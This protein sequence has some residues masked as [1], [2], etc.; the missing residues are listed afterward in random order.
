[1]KRPRIAIVSDPLVQRGG[2]ERVVEVMA[3]TFPDAPVF[4]LLY[5]KESG[6]ASLADRVVPSMLNRIPGATKR[7][8]W[9][10][11]LYPAAIESFDLSGYD[12]ILSSHHSVAKNVL[13]GADQ[14]HISY[15]HTPMRALWERSLERRS[16]PKP[17]APVAETVMRTMRV[18]DYAGAAHVDEF[19]AN[20]L[21][22]QRRIAR[23][24]R[25]ESTIL[26]PPIDTTKFRPATTPAGDYYLVASRLIPYKRVDLAVAATAAIGRRLVVVGAGP[27]VRE[28]QEPHVDYRGHVDDA[29]L[30][31]LMQGARAMIFGAN[32]D[33]GMAPVE[34]MACG[35]PVV[36]YGEGGARETV[37]DG[38][39]GVFS[40]EQSTAAFVDAIRRFETMALDPVAIRAH[41]ETFSR[42]RFVDKLRELV[43]EGYDR[44]RS[45][46]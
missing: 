6:P 35:R 36:A 12:I 38:V 29:E 8:R 21:T 19:I 28:I 16:F 45:A 37:V 34:M 14:F 27:G 31:G 10:F 39:T 17:L 11:P 5:S 24:Y 22:T 30:V 18:W 25:R 9:L 44:F 1:V 26:A 20:S 3:E 7:H 32:E 33:F 13:R 15:C 42:A 41:A 43:V 4:A 2:A 46:G 40:M 23:H